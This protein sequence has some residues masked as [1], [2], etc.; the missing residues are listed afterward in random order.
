ML[1]SLLQVGGD[2]SVTKL[3]LCRNTPC[4]GHMLVDEH[5]FVGEAL[6]KIY[7][8]TSLVFKMLTIGYIKECIQSKPSVEDYQQKSD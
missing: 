2:A 7:N 6:A 3:H 5:I 8:P 1:L 4:K